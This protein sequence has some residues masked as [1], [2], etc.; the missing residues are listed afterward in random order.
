[1]FVVVTPAQGG[2]GD[3]V[4]LPP[5][6]TAFETAAAYCRDKDIGQA[7]SRDGLDPMKDSV[8]TVRIIMDP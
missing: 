4:V 6:T 1:M 8:C 7:Y 5:G 2:Q 3:R